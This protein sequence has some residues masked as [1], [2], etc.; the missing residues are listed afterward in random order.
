MG[1]S[2]IHGGSLHIY[3]Y[4]TYI[5]IYYGKTMADFQ[6]ACSI[7]ISLKRL[8]R[9]GHLRVNRHAPDLSLEHPMFKHTQISYQYMHIFQ[10]NPQSFPMISLKTILISSKVSQISH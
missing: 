7:P 9:P 5:Y 8:Q 3:I 4:Y 2:T 10:V 6:R 1:N